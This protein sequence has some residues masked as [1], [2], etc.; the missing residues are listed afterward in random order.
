MENNKI[1]IGILCIC[2]N[3]MYWEFANEMLWGLNTFFLKHPSIKDKYDTKLLL[4]SDI[5]Q[6]PQVI[7]DK[8]AQYLA[9]RGEVKSSV[10][11]PTEVKL[12]WDKEQEKTTGELIGNIIAIR[13]R[14]AI[15][16]ETE[17]VEWPLPTLLRYN[18]FLQQE[19]EI[20]DFDYLFYID[21]DMRITDWIGEE[22]LGE[23][24]TAAQH[25]MYAL[26]QNLIPPY[27]DNP[28]SSAY[29]PRPGRLLEEDGKTRF[30]PLYYAGGF[31]GGKTEDFIKAMKVMRERIDKDFNNNYIA[32]WNDESHWNKYLSEVPPTI[33]LNPS[34]IYP[35]SLIAEYYVKQVWGRNYSPKIMTLTKRFSTSREG[36][37]AVSKLLSL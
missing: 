36:G 28:N 6:E 17:P 23:G 9:M 12:L 25:P 16:F 7:G 35:D 8:I 20:K 29:I 19:E 1:K 22:I 37:E 2:L 5:P 27:E 13:E 33:A 14:G 10:I 4:W 21:V 11:S 3:P 26:K 15:I 24:L 32:K 30:Q 31:Q 18:L 34:Y